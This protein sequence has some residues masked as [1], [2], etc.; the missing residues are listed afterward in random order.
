VVEIDLGDGQHQQ[1]VTQGSGRAAMILK[2][3]D[4]KELDPGAGKPNMVA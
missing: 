4:I 1:S 3:L 2:T